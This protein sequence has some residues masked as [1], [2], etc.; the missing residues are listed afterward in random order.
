MCV[1]YVGTLVRRLLALLHPK[2]GVKQKLPPSQADRP[3]TVS[4]D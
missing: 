4:D 3:M 2:A 1:K